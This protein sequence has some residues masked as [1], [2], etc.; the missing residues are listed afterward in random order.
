MMATALVM[1]S[2]VLR[3]MVN[4]SHRP[5]LRANRACADDG[6]SGRGA[7]YALPLHTNGTVRSE[8]KISSTV[9]GLVGPLDDF[10]NFGTSVACVGDLNGDGFG[11]I[12][13]GARLDG[14]L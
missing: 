9:G 10:D 1:L 6:G 8:Q 11:D 12:V 2:W 3:K 5:S 14:T 13:V 7:I 4:F